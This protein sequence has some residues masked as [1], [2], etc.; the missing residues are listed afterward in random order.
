MHLH[1]TS[2]EYFILPFLLVQGPVADLNQ[3]PYLSLPKMP[4]KIMM[5]KKE[6]YVQRKL[7]VKTK[8]R[9]KHRNK[10][11]HFK[12]NQENCAHF[13]KNLILNEKSKQ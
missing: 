13:A 3:I 5:S 10:E 4:S 11:F 1:D 6:D 2:K 9:Y 12:M 7:S 8:N